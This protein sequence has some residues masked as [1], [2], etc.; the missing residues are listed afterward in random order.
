MVT[1]LEK[2]QRGSL[3]VSKDIGHWMLTGREA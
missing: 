3:D 1:I 2:E